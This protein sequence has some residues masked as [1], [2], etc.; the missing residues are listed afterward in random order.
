MNPNQRGPVDKQLPVAD[1]LTCQE[2]AKLTEGCRQKRKTTGE[3]ESKKEI[4]TEL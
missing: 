3:G 1:T 2:W 4:I